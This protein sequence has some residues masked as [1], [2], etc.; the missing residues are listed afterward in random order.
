MSL[1]CLWIYLGSGKTAAFLLP[2]L[3]F[4]SEL[5][6][7]DDSNSANG[8]YAIVLAPT[9]ELALQ[10]ESETSKLAKPLGYRSVAI[11]GGHS[12]AEQSFNM[13]NGAEIIIATP[14]RLKDCLDQH[15]L[16]LHQCTYVVMDEAD[17]MVDLGFE[18]DM[19]FI[20]NSL[21]VSNTKPDSEAAESGS[22]ARNRYRQTTMFS[23]TMPPA[24]ERLAKT[25]LR[26][27]AVVTIGV[28][29]Q[30]VESVEQIVEL[31][32]EEKKKQVDGFYGPLLRLHLLCTTCLVILFI[33][34]TDCLKY[35]K[36][37]LKLLLL[38]L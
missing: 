32:A 20:L 14:G 9:R 37:V 30:A 17:R 28:A 24:V 38:F 1:L 25:Y 5:P 23:A 27:P 36:V 6:K 7:L 8:P 10:I 26:R 4:I 13:R 18:A 19:S 33:L 34:G 12:I 21:P 11:V 31:V 3:V 15:I 29:G 16:V 35:L 2:M 22:L